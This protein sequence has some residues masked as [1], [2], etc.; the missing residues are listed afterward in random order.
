M[1]VDVSHS[2]LYDPGIEG[3]V[4]ISPEESPRGR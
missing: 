4:H 2:V 1:A 3:P